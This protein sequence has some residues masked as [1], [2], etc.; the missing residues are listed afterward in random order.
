MFDWEYAYNVW[1]GIAHQLKGQAITEGI[2]YKVPKIIIPFNNLELELSCQGKGNTATTFLKVEFSMD[3][4]FKFTITPRTANSTVVIRVDLPVQRLGEPELDQNFVI[5]TSNKPKLL[6]LLANNK[7][8][9]AITS[10]L[11]SPYWG[12]QNQ[13]NGKFLMSFQDTTL[14]IDQHRIEDLVNLFKETLDLLVEMKVMSYK[15]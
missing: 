1:G 7:I 14:I 2:D 11:C 12:I 13:P 8:K 5:R 4:P 15:F 6:Q 10:K 3:V 9:T